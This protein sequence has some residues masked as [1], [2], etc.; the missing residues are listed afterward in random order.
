MHYVIIAAGSGS[1]LARNGPKPLVKPLDETLVERL[2]RIVCGCCNAESITVAVNA[3]APEVARHVH[4]LALNP[5]PRVL[6]VETCGAAETLALAASDAPC[7]AITVDSVFSAAYFRR[8]IEEF[9]GAE[10]LMGVTGFIDDE[11]PLYVDV[12]SEGNVTAF[13]DAP[14]SLLVSAGIYGLRSSAL[15]VLQTSSHGGSLREFQR[16]LL[17]ESVPVRAFDVGIAIDVDRPKDID[18]ARQFILNENL[19]K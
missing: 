3:K 18:V 10:C 14:T 4:S 19:R 1:R 8:F 12:D 5:R 15:Q 13:S 2:L 7:V 11:K 9:E 6:E 17:I 16:R